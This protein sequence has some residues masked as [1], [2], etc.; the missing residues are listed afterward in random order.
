MHYY[1]RV[2]SFSPVQ[3]NQPIIDAIK[4]INSRNKALLT[5][6]HDFFSLRDKYSTQ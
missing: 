5:A 4:K 3:N 6:T 1:S 2:K